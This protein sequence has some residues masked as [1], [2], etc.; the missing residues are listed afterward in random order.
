MKIISIATQKGGAGKTTV[1]LCLAVAA[2]RDGKSVLVVD[3]D[4][5]ATASKWG[6]R[7][8]QDT[9][10]VTSAQAARLPNILKAAQENG[11]AFVIID[12]PPRLEQA[13][14][15]AAKVADL[16]LIPCLPA[17][18]DL[19]TLDTTMDLLKYAGEPKA[20]VVLNGVPARGTRKEQAEHVVRDKT[21]PIAPVS[22]GYR[23]AFP[24]AAA[25]G[26]TP[27]EYDPRGRGAEETKQLY[28][29]VCEHLNLTTPE[30]ENTDATQTRLAA[31]H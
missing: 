25:L 3:L 18:N 4:P 15:A 16:I 26:Q 23:T 17:I 20:V 19:D 21:I 6:D 14:L 7:R 24:D 30:Q 27:Q 9:P 8:Q 1:A 22:F 12:T 11:A 31:S 10:V 5:Q 29:F 2:Q 13:S 28:M